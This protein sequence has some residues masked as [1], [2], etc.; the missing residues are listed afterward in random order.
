MIIELNTFQFNS[1]HFELAFFANCSLGT[2]VSPG[3]SFNDFDEHSFSFPL[4]SNRTTQFC[5]PQDQ[6]TLPQPLLRILLPFPLG[7]VVRSP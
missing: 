6:T 3:T 7:F 2:P 4:K 5:A 1:I